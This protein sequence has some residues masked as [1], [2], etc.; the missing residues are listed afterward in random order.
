L[1]AAGA[2]AQESK[3]RTY[4]LTAPPLDVYDRLAALKVGAVPSLSEP[5]RK[6]LADVWALKA[7][8]PGEAVRVEDDVLLNA[9]LFASGVEDKEA[10]RKYGERVET[11]VAEAK[12]AVKGAKGDRE[13]GEQLMKFLHG[14]VLNKGYAADQTSFTAALDSGRYNCVAAVAVYHLFGA[15][16]GLTLR[17]ISI[18]GAA[19]LPGHASLDLIDGKYRVQVEP[20]NP[21]GF[22][23]GTKVKKPGVRVI[24]Y[25]PDRAKGH[26][27]D[28]VAVA[29]MIYSNRGTV[30][31]DKKAPKPEEAARC[32]LAA[33]CLDPADET[34]AN[35]L[36]SLLTNWGP[37]LAAQKK[38]EDGV[39]VLAFGAEV[40]PKSDRIRGN[41]RFVWGEYI[42]A[43]LADGKDRDA[44]ALVGR[45]AKAFPDDKERGSGTYWF[46]RH[47]QKHLPTGKADWEAV[48]AIID[49]G[50]QALPAAEATE[51][52]AW[53]GHVFRLWSQEFLGKK[54]ADGSLKVLARG[55]ALDPKDATVIKGIGYHVEKALAFVEKASGREAMV[56]HFDAVRGQFPDLGAVAE[57]GRDH[58]VLT[59]QTLAGEK[60]FADAV[61]A[62]KAYEP[63]LPKAE[64]RAK[65]GGI[66]YDRWARHLTGVK[67]KENWKA[68]LEKYAE[69]LKAFP[70]HDVLTRNAVNAVRQWADPTI[71]AGKWDDALAICKEGLDR[72]PDNEKLKELKAYCEKRKMKDR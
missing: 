25:V 46:R 12:A 31:A 8:K 41:L 23:W 50:A 61:A 54:D 53:R 68:G 11:L 71:K 26:E 32:Y 14:S 58:A 63:L 13:G 29:A 48:L 35:N 17:P 36:D 18:P 55:H 3:P 67:G 59:V 69:G 45:V 52:V 33:L 19:A 21:D 62:V 34:A 30:L 2:F 56:K 6:V 28:A 5:E 10:R 66:A 64:D 65:A 22:D 42:D 39:R 37:A 43:T 51:L 70:G 4:P 15:R 27:V 38:Y 44:V 7:K 72:L 24:G 16:L 47:A 40:L 20:T 1:A 57:A 9:L 49:R 60:K